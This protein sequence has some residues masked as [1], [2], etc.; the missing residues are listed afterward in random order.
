MIMLVLIAI[1]IQGYSYDQI[2]G[3]GGLGFGMLQQT[4]WAVGSNNSGPPAGGTPQIQ[5]HPTQVSDRMKKPCTNVWFHSVHACM[6][7]SSNKHQ[8]PYN[9][10]F[11]CEHSRCGVGQPLGGGGGV[12]DLTDSDDCRHSQCHVRNNLI[13]PSSAARGGGG[14][15][16]PA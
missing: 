9:D 2:H 15:G 5:V 1:C 7:F 11:T 16:P 13:H 12:G 3:L 6:I 10:S 14:T 8:P 4:A